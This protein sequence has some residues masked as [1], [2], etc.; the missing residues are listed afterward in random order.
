MMSPDLTPDLADMVKD[1]DMTLEQAEQMLSAVKPNPKIISLCGNLVS[2][3]ALS[4]E[5]AGKILSTIQ[6]QEHRRHL[7]VKQAQKKQDNPLLTQC[8]TTRQEAVD[9]LKYHSTKQ[10]KRV[11]VGSSG[12][13]RVLLE[14]VSKLS[15]TRS[16]LSAKRVKNSSECGC[17][18][19]AVIRKSKD[20]GLSKPWRLKKETKIED[21]QHSPTC[22]SKGKL[23]F[24][25]LKMN[26]KT[27]TSRV[28][29]SIKKT[30]DRIAR[31]NKVPHCYVSPY[32][33]AKT[34]LA[35]AKQI[36][37]DYNANWSKLDA[38]GEQLRDENP[39]SVVHVDV[40]KKG[41]FKRMFV[42]LKSAAWVSANTGTGIHR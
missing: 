28:L 18:Y 22:T 9:A 42:G 21:L 10:G 23:T 39:G 3:G 35:E 27:S 13:K 17:K 19:S 30:R 2:G 31:D 6:S 40:D 32:V 37:A 7:S 20:K 36:S 15:G 12:S 34:R 41:R 26:L 5:D 25:E 29:P 11:L 1:G 24:R 14:C 38:W 8:W 33:A 16:K 4:P